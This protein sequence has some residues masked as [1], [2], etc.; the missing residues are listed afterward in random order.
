MTP[1]RK[2]E[3][4]KTHKEAYFEPTAFLTVNQSPPKNKPHK[5]M[6]PINGNMMLSVVFIFIVLYLSNSMQSRTP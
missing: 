1:V 5:A 3:L 6:P 4:A 2:S